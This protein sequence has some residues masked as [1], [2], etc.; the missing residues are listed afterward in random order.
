MCRPGD[1]S[2][3]KW[4]P[5]SKCHKLLLI[6]LWSR[7]IM[8]PSSYLAVFHFMMLKSIYTTEIEKCKHENLASS[9]TEKTHRTYMNKLK[10]TNFSIFRSNWFP[11]HWFFLLQVYRW[12]LIAIQEKLFF[13]EFLSHFRFAYA[14]DLSTSHLFLFLEHYKI[15]GIFV[16]ITI[17]VYDQS[18]WKAKR[19]KVKLHHQTSS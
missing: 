3:S 6:D 13:H 17:D 12:I 10:V 1:C 4:K 9:W 7:T 2:F 5:H 19:L 18:T 8:F 14:F 15:Y 11:F 16:S